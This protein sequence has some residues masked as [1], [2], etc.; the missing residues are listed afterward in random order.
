MSCSVRQEIVVLLDPLPFFDNRKSE[1]VIY[2][3]VLFFMSENRGLCK[4]VGINADFLLEIWGVSL[5]I[6]NAP[7]FT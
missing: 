5:I 6:E 7:L 1:E 2:K 4:Q 3:P